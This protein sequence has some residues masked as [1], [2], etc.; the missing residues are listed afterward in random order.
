MVSRVTRS[1]NTINPA[2]GE[3]LST[4][5]F[6]SLEKAKTTVE[7]SHNVFKEQWSRLSVT[8]RADYFRSLAKVLRDGRTAY[9]STM[10]SEMGKP[11]TQ[12]LSEVDKV[13]WSAEV[14]ADKA[15]EWLAEEKVETD[16]KRSFVSFEPQ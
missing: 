9:A 14:F 4:Y 15:S 16:A 11:I 8:Q 13:A 1:F 10:T 7:Q 12:S 5:D 6:D 3:K 2:T